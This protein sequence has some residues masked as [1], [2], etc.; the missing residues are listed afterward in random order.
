[1]DLLQS[2]SLANERAC[3]LVRCRV[4]GTVEIKGPDVWFSRVLQALRDAGGL[5]I[6]AVPTEDEASFFAV[7][8]HYAGNY[9]PIA[10]HKAY[11][12]LSPTSAR[13]TLPSPLNP[14]I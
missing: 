14:L 7:E 1:M 5:P 6:E 13:A 9:T 3:R 8:S 4:N 10:S 12:F 2:C 11:R